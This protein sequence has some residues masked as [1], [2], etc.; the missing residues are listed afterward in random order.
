[1]SGGHVVVRAPGGASS[2]GL[3]HVWCRLLGVAADLSSLICKSGLPLPWK[4]R[5]RLAR[6]ALSGIVELHND[7]IVHRDIKTEN[8]LVSVTGRSCSD[9]G[10]SGC[11]CA[12]DASPQ[13]LQLLLLLTSRLDGSL[14][15]R[16]C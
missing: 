15:A 6:D 13:G 14:C 10:G 2:F 3:A 7:E 8:I 9:G 11:G 1:M 4:L 16:M 5:A 12:H